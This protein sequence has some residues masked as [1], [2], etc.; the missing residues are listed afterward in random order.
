M[1]RS[2]KCLCDKGR[3]PFRLYPTASLH[4]HM[5]LF[6]EEREAEE[7]GWQEGRRKLHEVQWMNDTESAAEELL[8]LSETSSRL[9]H[10]PQEPATEGMEYP[11][12]LS[13]SVADSY[14]TLAPPTQLLSSWSPELPVYASSGTCLEGQAQEPNEEQ[15]PDEEVTRPPR[16]K[17]VKKKAKCIRKSDPSEKKQIKQLRN[18]ISAQQSRDRKKKEAEDL[19]ADTLRLRS[20][21]ERLAHELKSAQEELDFLHRVVNALPPDSRTE[22]DLLQATIKLYPPTTETE[23]AA[24][25][26]GKAAAPT[27]SHASVNPGSNK[28][29]ALMAMVFI[30]CLCFAAC[31]NPCLS[32]VA[33]APA[34]QAVR[35]TREMHEAT[36]QNAVAKL[37]AL[38]LTA[39]QYLRLLN[40]Q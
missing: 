40:C 28:S 21:S 11:S 4:Y 8:D 18:R 10:R 27:A 39:T 16:R 22:F 12:P 7:T 24:R 19:K 5:Q 33:S 34:Y 23:Q 37:P 15:E 3:R 2:S 32:Q 29:K 20:E 17:S 26:P 35:D 36:S 13:S 25:R 1:G 31:L 38:K 6:Q 30:G 9:T 14:T